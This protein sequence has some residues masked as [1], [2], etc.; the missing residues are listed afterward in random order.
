MEGS[1][2]L[3]VAVV[4]VQVEA[5][6]TTD[7]EVRGSILPGN[8]FFSISYQKCV[9]NQVPCGSVSLLIFLYKMLSCAA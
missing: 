5:H 8:C 7:R 1:I 3:N 9:L 6:R 2:L 4:V